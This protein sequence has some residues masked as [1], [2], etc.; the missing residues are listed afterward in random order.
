MYKKKHKNGKFY[1]CEKL[2]FTEFL[3]LQRRDRKENFTIA[4]PQSCIVTVSVFVG[5]SRPVEGNQKRRRG[6]ERAQSDRRPQLSDD[7]PW[8][9]DGGEPERLTDRKLGRTGLRLRFCVASLRRGHFSFNIQTPERPPS[10]D[11][12]NCKA[13]NRYMRIMNK[14]QNKNQLLLLLFLFLL[15]N[16]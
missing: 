11:L 7:P 5:I 6:R 1:G 8:H 2:Y 4:P 13:G 15:L 9:R 10:Q 3:Y 16:P 14:V 12:P